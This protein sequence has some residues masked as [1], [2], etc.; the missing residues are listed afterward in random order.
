MKVYKYLEFVTL[1]SAV[2]V[3]N[4]GLESTI[5]V[6]RKPQMIDKSL[7]LVCYESLPY[8]DT[9][10]WCVLGKRLDFCN[11]RVSRENLN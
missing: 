8:F 9:P 5:S 10:K 3:S 11:P 6:L 4:E 7:N 2:K 1:I